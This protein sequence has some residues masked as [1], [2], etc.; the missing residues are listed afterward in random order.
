MNVFHGIGFTSDRVDLSG[1]MAGLQAKYLDPK[2]GKI[3]LG[4]DSKLAFHSIYS[5]SKYLQAQ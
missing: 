2:A 1:A 3:E 4:S 5:F